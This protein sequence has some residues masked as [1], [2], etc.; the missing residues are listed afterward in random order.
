MYGVLV[1]DASMKRAVWIAPKGTTRL[2][3]HASMWATEGDAQA[4]VRALMADARNAHLICRVERI[5][6]SEAPDV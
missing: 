2:T 4:F 5:G 3:I 6:A 1:K